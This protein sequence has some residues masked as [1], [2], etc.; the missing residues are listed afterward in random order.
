MEKPGKKLKKL[1]II[2]GTT[3][4]VYAGFRY[5]LPLVAPFLAGYV[6]ALLLRPS[7]RFFSYRLRVTLRGRRRHVPVGVVGGV[8]LLLVLA[9]LG[10]LCYHLVLKLCEEGKML[11][12]QLPR[13]LEAFDCWLTGN[14]RLMEEAFGLRQDSLCRLAGEMLADL[15]DM[16]RSA[17][18]PFL[19]ENSMTALHFLAKAAL[20]GLVSFL[21]AVLSLQEMEELRDRRDQSMFRREFN[22]IGNRL[23]QTGKAW[24]R[25]QGIILCI[26]TAL[27]IAGMLL[28]KNPYYLLA[29]IGV[30]ILDA[31]PIF[32]TG[33]VL[34]PWAVIEIVSHEWRQAL[35]LLGL[36][37]VCYFVRQILEARLMGS[38]VGLSPLEP[39]T[40]VYVGLELFGF[41]GFIL[42]PL[43]LLLIEDLTEMWA[44]TLSF[45]NL[46]S[47][48]RE[49]GRCSGFG[50]K[51]H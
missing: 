7:A 25:S 15:T 6:F 44:G 24:F 18:M 4:A 22:L 3:G 38:Q 34:I 1:F 26:T 27:C 48:C 20:V 37:L 29:G 23:V 43:G 12:L 10:G 5:L 14:C 16:G 17:A 41:L 2:I 19:M 36:Y 8:E 35:I 39:L 49:G 33:T 32:G 51:K 46:R 50:P 28:V 31:L 47:G 42:G 21:A 9:L 40:T 30:G 11:M 45:R 13:W